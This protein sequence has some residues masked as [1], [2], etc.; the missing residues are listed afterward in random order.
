MLERGLRFEEKLLG[1]WGDGFDEDEK[2]GREE[3]SS[4]LSKLVSGPSSSSGWK[5]FTLQHLSSVY[6]Y[7]DLSSFFLLQPS[8][9]NLPSSLPPSFSLPNPTLRC[10]PLPSLDF[11]SKDSGTRSCST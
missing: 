5:T 6:H 10:P 7:P 1:C 4:K 2:K 8:S 9:T 11:P 3:V